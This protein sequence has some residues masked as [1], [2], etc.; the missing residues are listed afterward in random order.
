[1]FVEANRVVEHFHCFTIHKATTMRT[2]KSFSLLILLAILSPYALIVAGL[3]A[4]DACVT[5][6][7]YDDEKCTGEPKREMTFPTWSKPGSPCCK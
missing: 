5:V 6:F 4:P 3:D 1:M 2:M 7:V